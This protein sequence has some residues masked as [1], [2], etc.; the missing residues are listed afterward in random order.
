MGV[1]F[2]FNNAFAVST[3]YS[4]LTKPT[5]TDEGRYTNIK[6]F[7]LVT[8]A[9]VTT[10]INEDNG[11]ISFVAV[12]FRARKYTYLDQQDF[13]NATTKT[14]I[15]D[16][17]YTNHTTVLGVAGMIGKQ[18]HIGYGNW[19]FEWN[20]G[21]G[22]RNKSVSREGTP[23]NSYVVPKQAGFLEMPNY[24]DHYMMAYVP[25]G[26]RIILKL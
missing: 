9:K 3:E 4:Y 24:M 7:R 18:I 5:W 16:Y 20:I 17:N 2:E 8:T 25:A 23:A 6:G 11:N 15:K 26:I 10:N 1:G 21:L 13:T 22:I 14:T 19:Y 12:E